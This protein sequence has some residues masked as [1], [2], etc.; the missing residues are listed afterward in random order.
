MSETLLPRNASELERALES[1]LAVGLNALDSEPPARVR[2]P[3]LIAPAHL[4]HLAWEVDV[5]VWRG[6]LTDTE[7]R[8]LIAQSP[9]LHRL[10]G[11][12]AGTARLVSW[13]GARLE[14]VTTRRDRAFAGPSLSDA[15]RSAWLARLPQLR[16]YAFRT[17]GVRHAALARPF[18]RC[19]PMSTARARLDHRVTL[20]RAGTESE[21]TTWVV[22]HGTDQRTARVERW[23]A[24]PAVAR[25]TH[26]G[27]FARLL[28]KSRAARRLYR[29]T[30][31]QTYA[32][33]SARF[34]ARM[35]PV[36]DGLT[37]AVA[38]WRPVAGQGRLA[39]RASARFIRSLPASRAADRLYAALS[40]A[41][42]AIVPAPRARGAYCTRG[43]LD[44]SAWRAELRVAVRGRRA[45]IKRHLA[46]HLA[47]Y[48]P[49]PL[50]AARDALAWGRPAA[51]DWKLD[52]RTRLPAR[53]G[54]F[55]AG[56]LT[57]GQLIAA[58]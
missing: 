55:M 42:P 26:A 51:A 41:D 24:L 35:L 37:P 58:R 20:V 2:R 39:P 50:A 47:A 22:E 4:S 34:S 54:A 17:R 32:H 23:V 7:R 10:A 19:L 6:S 36:P 49:A 33:P 52:P 53:A 28:V 44:P 43:R 27:R 18:P 3:A 25:G 8:A 5:P 1:A 29:M 57:A 46:G 48:N 15:E 45:G 11:T 12:H 14:R 31:V 13:A 38:Q 16:R 21:L 56:T 40:L 9:D 30:E